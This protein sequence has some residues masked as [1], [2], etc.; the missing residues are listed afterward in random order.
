MYEVLFSFLQLIL[1]AL[2]EL[3]VSDK[4]KVA[5]ALSSVYREVTE[6]T[7]NGSEIRALMKSR[8]GWHVYGERDESPRH[9]ESLLH[10]QEMRIE[11]LKSVLKKEQIESLLSIKVPDL[12]PVMLQ[13]VQEKG[14]TI[15]FWLGAIDRNDPDFPSPET[16]ED[17]LSDPLPPSEFEITKEVLRIPYQDDIE[18]A[19]SRLSDIKALSDRLREFLATEF[20]VE[21]LL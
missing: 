17:V 20:S 14:T 15:Q 13:L 9:L 6:L 4:K 19:E 21:D 2:P 7:Q 8:A 10:D 12:H 16:C 5:K 3:R 11:R 18:A 1:S